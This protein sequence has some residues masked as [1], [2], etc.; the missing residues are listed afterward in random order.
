MSNISLTNSLNIV[1][2]PQEITIESEPKA[3]PKPDKSKIH[4]QIEATR[5]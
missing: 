4:E 5:T 2:G 3:E 1:S